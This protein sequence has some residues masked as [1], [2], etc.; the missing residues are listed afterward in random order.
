MPRVP[1]SPCA[2]CGRMLWR[3]SGSRPI[4]TAVCR[5]CRRETFEH[6]TSKG[7]RGGCRCE[8]CRAWNRESMQAYAR[9]RKAEGRPIAPS[10]E[11]RAK[12]R[13]KAKAQGYTDRMRSRDAARRARKMGAT[14]ERF[15]NAEVFERDTWVCG[16][17]GKGTD[18]EASYPAPLMPTLDHIVPLS[19]GGAHSRENTRCAHLACNLRRGNRM[20]AV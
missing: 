5:P 13:A 8:A 18:R 11:S 14:V 12:D 4:G 19:L 16:I 10:A 1:D 15:S 2:Q 6:G 7:Y 20:E 17:C 3:G 9:K